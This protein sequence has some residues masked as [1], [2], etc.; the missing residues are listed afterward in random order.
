M[1]KASKKLNSGEMA[2]LNGCSYA[3]M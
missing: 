3:L 2:T 1:G